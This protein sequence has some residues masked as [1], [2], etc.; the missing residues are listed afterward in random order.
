MTNVA[1]RLM[2]AL[3]AMA[4]LGVSAPAQAQ[5]AEAASTPSGAEPTE[6]GSDGVDNSSAFL[7]TGKIGGIVPFSGLG[8]FVSGAIEL[9]WVFGKTKQRIGALLDVSYTVPHADGEQTEDYEGFDVDRI[10]DGTYSWELR[11]KLLT[12]QPTFLYRLTG[13]GRVVPYGGIGPRL[14]LLESVVEGKSGGEAF[15]VSTEQSTKLGFGV[16]LGAEFQLGPGGLMAELLFQWGPLT[17]EIT[18]DSNLGSAT[19][20][21]GYRALLF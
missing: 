19:L 14:Y 15:A 10:P 12:F 17:H 21:V 8:P 16:P 3:A 13:L 20:F 9:G 11:Q 6:K 7:A 18:G 2:A 4:T 5:T 1:L